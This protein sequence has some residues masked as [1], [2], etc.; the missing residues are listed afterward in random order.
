MQPRSEN[1]P[2]PVALLPPRRRHSREAG[3]PTEARRRRSRV[4]ATENRRD[5]CIRVPGDATSGSSPRT[6]LPEGAGWPGVGH[7][8]IASPRFVTPCGGMP[9]GSSG[10]RGLR[11]PASRW[12]PP[13]RGRSTIEDGRNLLFRQRRI[14][15]RRE[16]RRKETH[17]EPF[18]G[19]LDL[20]Q[21][22]GQGGK[23]V[24]ECCEGSADG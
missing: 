3:R 4:A 21:R 6:L 20:Q 19:H 1:D 17:L 8:S 18:P 15:T 9:T 2:M 13:A 22:L 14:V 16:M 5:T 24:V 12:N 10:R 23:T 7:H 11:S